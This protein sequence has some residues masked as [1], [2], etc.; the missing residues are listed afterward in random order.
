VFPRDLDRLQ[1]LIA[2]YVTE[3]D[4]DIRSTASELL[5]L[6]FRFRRL[7][8]ERNAWHLSKEINSASPVWMGGPIHLDVDEGAC[9]DETS[10]AGGDYG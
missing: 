9:V 2:P 5:G 7:L 4:E 1:K 3:S 6:I 10:E 8:N